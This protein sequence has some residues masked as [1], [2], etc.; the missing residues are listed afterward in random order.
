M[1]QFKDSF[2]LISF[3]Y[4]PVISLDEKDLSA[5]PSI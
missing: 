5:S 3:K 1:K 4:A 2:F